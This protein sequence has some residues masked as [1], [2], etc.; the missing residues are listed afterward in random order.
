MIDEIREGGRYLQ[1]G[2]TIREVSL[3]PHLRPIF[4]KV[5]KTCEYFFTGKFDTRKIP[6]RGFIFLGVPGTGK[7]ELGK[8]VARKLDIKLRGMGTKV[9]LFLVDGAEI[10][11]PKWG[12]AEENLKNIFSIAKEDVRGSHKS[13]VILL[14]DDI[15]SLIL[16]RGMEI[17]KEWHYSINSILFHEL[18]E[19]DSSNTIVIATSNKPELV[20]DAILNRLHKVDFPEIPL[21]DLMLRVEE[22]L[23]ESGI[24]NHFLEELKSSIKSKL[25]K[26]ENPTL[27]DAEHF[28]ID[29]CIGRGVWK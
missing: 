7:T 16:K 8:Q 6:F 11:A 2:K 18:D 10:A 29:E 26:I 25:E 12:K 9:K 13:K 24:E 22:I 1:D 17:A 20:D 3:L 19:I 21:Q 27:R 28:T 15:E 14:F 23:S 5:Y 4:E